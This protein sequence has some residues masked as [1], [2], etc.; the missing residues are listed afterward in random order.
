M[1]IRNIRNIRESGELIM[2]GLRG[3][4]RCGE[5]KQNGRAH[6]GKLVMMSCSHAYQSHG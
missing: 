6:P 3:T 5:K 1:H 2:S 4:E